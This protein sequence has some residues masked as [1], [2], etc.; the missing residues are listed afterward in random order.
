[1]HTELHLQAG[2][3]LNLPLAGGT[4]VFCAAGHVQLAWHGP[5]AMQGL[6]LAS[7]QAW[8]AASAGIVSLRA[9][10]ACRLRLTPEPAAVQ[11]PAKTNSLRLW[12]RRLSWGAPKRC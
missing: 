11:V 1:M 6:R 8:R 12:G 2:Q 10:D 3:D 9:S 4:E 5:A 7:G